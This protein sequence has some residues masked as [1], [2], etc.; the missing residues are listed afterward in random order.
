[1]YEAFGERLRPAPPLVALEQSQ[2]LGKKGGLG[3]YVYE[4]GKEKEVDQS[5]YREVGVQPSA[6]KLGE[7]D[8]QHR[9]VFVM[10]NEAARIL[11][12][13]IVATPGDVDLGMIMGTGF[14][15][16]RGGLLRYADKVGLASIV[17]ELERYRTQY[18]E[19]F[20]PAPLLLRKAQAG[21]KFYAGN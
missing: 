21:E 20:E 16:F 12:D 11:E 6:V 15:P 4:N 9:A 3:F 14:P 2:R 5:I 1:M 7:R 10:I 18:G 19:R 13:G 8:I 17:Q